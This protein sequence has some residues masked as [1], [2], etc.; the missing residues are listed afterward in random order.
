MTKLFKSAHDPHV[1]LIKS[2]ETFGNGLNTPP[3]GNVEM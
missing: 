3:T 2:S 1:P